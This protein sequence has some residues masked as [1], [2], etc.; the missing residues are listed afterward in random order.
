MENIRRLLRKSILSIMILTG[1][2]MSA[3]NS[4]PAPGNGGAPAPPIGNNGIGWNP[5][6]NLPMWGGAN[7][8]GGPWYDNT[9]SQPV[10]SGG[11]P[12][13]GSIR[14]MA[15]GYDAQG[16]LRVIPMVVNFQYNGVQ[17]NVTVVNAWNPWTDMWNRDLMQPAFNT[18]YWLNN[19]EYDYY[20]P[21]STGT[22]Y[23]NL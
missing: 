17:Y 10:F 14:V 2:T 18:D 5:G 19:V 9:W 21:L 4:L 20:V 16:I 3:Q 15:C 6:P 13:R 7:M 22:Y 12:A 23:F 11:I 1:I 8:N